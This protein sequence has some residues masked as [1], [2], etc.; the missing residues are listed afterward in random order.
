MGLC[1]SQEEEG[2]QIE[3]GNS[4]IYATSAKGTGD[5]R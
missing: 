2:Y 5:L 3:E 1:L 4:E